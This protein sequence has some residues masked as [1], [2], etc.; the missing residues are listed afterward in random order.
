MIALT[1]ALR[2]I[3]AIGSLFVFLGLFVGLETLAH[4]GLSSP[5]QSW[6]MKEPLQCS[7]IGINTIIRKKLSIFGGIKLLSYI[8]G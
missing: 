7:D 1:Y 6:G 2:L 8:V 5:S 3:L 4:I